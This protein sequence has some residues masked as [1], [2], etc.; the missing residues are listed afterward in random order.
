MCVFLVLLKILLQK[1]LWSSKL[2][3]TDEER[4]Y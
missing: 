1:A 4:A 2:V 3:E